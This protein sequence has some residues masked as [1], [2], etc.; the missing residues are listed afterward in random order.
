MSF[1]YWAHIYSR[2][3][4][5]IYILIIRLPPGTTRTDTPIPSATRFR[6]PSRFLSGE[7]WNTLY[8]DNVYVVPLD[9]VLGP[10]GFKKQISGFNVERLG[11]RDRKSTRLNSS[12]SCAYRMPTYDCIKKYQNT[13]LN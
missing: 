13:N 2:R 12:Q 1:F 8:F 7:D 10:C 4:F 5:N 11:N 6:S 9:I 3:D